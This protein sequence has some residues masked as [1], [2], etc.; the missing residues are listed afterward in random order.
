MVDFI[1]FAKDHPGITVDI[2]Y[3]KHSTRGIVITMSRS[4]PSIKRFRFCLGNGPYANR[5]EHINYFLNEGLK[6]LNKEDDK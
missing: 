6:V 1:E 4:Q 3:W 2:E 5:D